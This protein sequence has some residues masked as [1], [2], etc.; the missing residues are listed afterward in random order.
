M[1]ADTRA[2]TSCV[3]ARCC[4]C[5]GNGKYGFSGDGGLATLA[6]LYN[7]QAIALDKRGGRDRALLA[8]SSNARVRVVNGTL[9]PEEL[10]P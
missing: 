5:T 7:A 6:R 10:Q 1:R 9:T 3:H 8:D 2:H 4:T